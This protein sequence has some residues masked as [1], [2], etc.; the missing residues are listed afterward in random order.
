[1]M[2]K[3][4][5]VFF[6]EPNSW[7]LVAHLSTAVYFCVC[8]SSTVYSCCFPWIR[9]TGLTGVVEYVRGVGG[10]LDSTL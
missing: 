8:M 5:A 7:Q 9:L 2:M 6:F 10:G 1:M 3:L 4:M